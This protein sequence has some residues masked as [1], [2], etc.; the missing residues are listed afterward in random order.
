MR[1]NVSGV[2]GPLRIQRL[3]AVRSDVDELAVGDNAVHQ[4][5]DV[6]IKD[7]VRKDPISLL[8]RRRRADG[9]LRLSVS[10]ADHEHPHGDKRQY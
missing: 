1:N 10:C 2:T 7:K 3:E 4:S 5:R 6:L 9:R 8:E